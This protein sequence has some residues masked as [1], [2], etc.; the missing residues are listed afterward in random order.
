MGVG[1]CPD[2]DEKPLR[3]FEVSNGAKRNGPEGE[4]LLGAL[5]VF[6]EIWVRIFLISMILGVLTYC[7]ALTKLK[8]Y[9]Q[10][11]Q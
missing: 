3:G 8:A 4:K 2:R 5:F 11:S 1:A 7:E 6:S 9:E 10:K